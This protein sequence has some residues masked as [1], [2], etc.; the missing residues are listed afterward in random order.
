MSN[1]AV[2]FEKLDLSYVQEELVDHEFENN[3]L[4]CKEKS[5]ADRGGLD[6][7]DKSNLAKALS[8]FANTGGGVLIFGL[9]ARK[10]DEIDEIIGIRPIKD[11]RRFESAL[12][13]Y[14]SRLVERLVPGV[15]YKQIETS[16]GEGMAAIYVP[17]S[18]HLPHRSL[19]DHKFY[20]RA[21]GT[22]SSIGVSLIEEMFSRRKKPMLEFLVKDN[23]T[24]VLA[25]RGEASARHPY[26]VFRL[27]DLV[28]GTGY[29]LD[30]NTRLTSWIHQYEYK[31]IKGRFLAFKG[32]GNLV[33]HPH[34]EVP[35]LELRGHQGPPGSAPTTSIEFEYHVYAED[36]IPREGTFVLQRQ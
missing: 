12:R 18:P 20:I 32:G 19:Q 3:W 8:G 10:R 7:K 6:E 9:A 36:M 16:P 29:E 1:A 24:V 34:A 27:P 28:G 13:E 5:G 14:E 4:E 31:S 30:G 33:I 25:N 11:L 22:F 26:V 2:L 21:G 17:E 23:L 15:E 35:L